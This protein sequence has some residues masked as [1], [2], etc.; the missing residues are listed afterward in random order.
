VHDIPSIFF[1]VSQSVLAI[2]ARRAF[3]VAAGNARDLA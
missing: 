3:G 2:R 1:V